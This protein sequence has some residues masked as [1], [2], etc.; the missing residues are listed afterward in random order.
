LR[1][2][3]W[4]SALLIHS[5]YYYTLVAS[6]SPTLLRRG[7]SVECFGVGDEAESAS[8]QLVV[9]SR[10]CR[11]GSRKISAVALECAVSERFFRS[12]VESF[13]II[14]ASHLIPSPFR[15]RCT[16]ARFE[17]ELLVQHLL[18]RPWVH[19]HLPTVFRREVLSS[20]ACILPA[21]IYPWLL[22]RLPPEVRAYNFFCVCFNTV[23]IDLKSTKQY[24][25]ANFLAF[26]LCVFSTRCL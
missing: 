2:Q 15:R 14:V 20:L 10:F 4:H 7:R 24:H 8:P 1:L 9:S 12:I 17:P 25:F 5:T 16:A 26:F 3:S 21:M 11:K 6:C 23:S 18:L 19:R 13:N 22:L